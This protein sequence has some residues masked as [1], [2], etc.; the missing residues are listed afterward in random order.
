MANYELKFAS[1]DFL[2]E[3]SVTVEFPECM[4]IEG[5]R[6]LTKITDQLNLE[7][8]HIIESSNHIKISKLSP[9]VK[10]ITLA[11]I[12]NPT[13]N[14]AGTGGITISTYTDE[15]FKNL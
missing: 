11:N 10:E 1:A 15:E 6:S 5:Q 14:C 13:E 9:G 7:I 2:Y 3:K 4:P 12:L 8:D